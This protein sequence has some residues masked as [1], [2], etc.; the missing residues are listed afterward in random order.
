MSKEASLIHDACSPLTA[1]RRQTHEAAS[2]GRRIRGI[3]GFA[4]LLITAAAGTY[5]VRTVQQPQ[6]P[7][8]RFGK[9]FPSRLE[10]RLDRLG[11]GRTVGDSAA[12]VQVMALV[13]YQCKAS[14]VA[15]DSIWPHLQPRVNAG[16]VRYTVH[17]LPLPIQPASVP[18]AAMLACTSAG[19]SP[20][21]FWTLREQVM[22]EQASWSAQKDPEAALLGMA[23][24][25][26][27][28]TAKVRGCM[29]ADDGALRRSL[30]GVW[31]KAD[32]AHLA[33]TPVY[34]VNGRIVFWGNVRA[35][36]DSL[37]RTPVN[38]NRAAPP[39]RGARRGSGKTAR[40]A[41]FCAS[42]D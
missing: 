26:G 16:R 9:P 21:A 6:P 32:H 23:A 20:G 5:A 33:F 25:A 39:A 40:S 4:A 38:A 3:D 42:G 12:P 31:K 24:R 10:Q 22:R 37:L 1:L 2:L 13:D 27:L 29:D 14:A 19:G 36:V 8:T 17:P 11:F 15:H 18:A 35:Q 28:D 34:A 41:T 7:Q 30:A